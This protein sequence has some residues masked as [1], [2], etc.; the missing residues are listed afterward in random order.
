MSLANHSD[1]SPFSLLRQTAT[2]SS[3]QWTDTILWL[4]LAVFLIVSSLFCFSYRHC[5][6]FLPRRPNEAMRPRD[7]EEP[8]LGAL[9]QNQMPPLVRHSLAR[10][11]EPSAPP[12]CWELEQR[13]SSS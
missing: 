4:F 5:C 3:M 9:S 2:A 12:L 10:E 6:R 11:F 13:G 8:L 7:M 1:A